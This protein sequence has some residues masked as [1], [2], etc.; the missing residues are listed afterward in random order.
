M[1]TSINF[2]ITLDSMNKASV[3]ISHAREKKSKLSD[4]AQTM[5]P[6]ERAGYKSYY[7]FNTRSNFLH[8]LSKASVCICVCLLFVLP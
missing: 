4:A 5:N 3:Y 6:H 7:T 2:K 8:G 1:D